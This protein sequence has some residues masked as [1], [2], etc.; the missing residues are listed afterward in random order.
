MFSTRLPR[1]QR[2][3][4]VTSLL[5]TERDRELMRQVYQNRFLRSTH[6]VS[7]LTGSHQQLLRRLQRLYHHGYLDRPRAQIDYY[8]QGSRPMVYGIGNKAMDFLTRDMGIPER[9]INWTAKNRTITR[10]FMEHALVISDVMVAIESSCRKHNIEC[11]RLDSKKLLKWNVTVHRDGVSTSIG[12]VPDRVFG[13]KIAGTTRWFFLEAD[14]AT[15]P[16]ER[17][18]LQQSSFARKLL[19]YHE[20]WRQKILNDSFP[21]FQVLTV[22]TTPERVR[23]LIAATRSVT[24][25]KGAGLFLFADRHAVDQSSDFLQVRVC[26]GRGEQL[27]LLDSFFLE[28]SHELKASAECSFSGPHTGPDP[29]QRASS[30][31]SP[32]EVIPQISAVK[33]KSSSPIP[34]NPSKIPHSPALGTPPLGFLRDLVHKP[35]P[36]SQAP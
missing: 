36:P 9:K 7:L 16:V 32:H 3:Q 10:L 33:L 15:M 31:D 1:F 18:N 28:Q 24:A 12:V 6:L 35:V 5:L 20:T 22:T 25:G 13:L 29:R 4:S 11:I 30:L 19:A 26:N 14:R 27:T 23:N 21:R 34:R 2:D 17:N 8:R